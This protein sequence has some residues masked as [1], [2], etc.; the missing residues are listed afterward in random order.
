MLLLGGLATLGLAVAL[1]LPWLDAGLTPDEIGNLQPGGWRAVLTDAE[2]AVNPPLWRL[3]A[4]LGGGG[5]VGAIRLGRFLSIAA[6]AALVPV[7]LLVGTRAG[8]KGAGLLSALGLAMLPVLVDVGTLHRAYA[9]WGLVALLLQ[10][11][12]VDALGCGG[13]VRWVAVALLGALLVQLH[14]LGV[15][16]LAA[17]LVLVAVE[18]RR[19]GLALLLGVPALLVLAP[20]LDLIVAGSDRRLASPDG[21]L[22]TVLRLASLGLQAPPEVVRIAGGG[23]RT[24]GIDAPRAQAWTGWLVVV[25]LVLHLP[26]LRR[27]STGRRVAWVGAVGVLG[28]AALAARGQYVRPHAASQLA[29][30]LVPLLAA[31]PGASRRAWVRVPGW[32]LLVGLV[33][34]SWVGQLRTTLGLLADRDA[35]PHFLAHAPSWARGR[36]LRVHPS[37]AAGWLW[38]QATGQ[39]PQRY[40]HLGRCERRRDCYAVGGLVWEGV[41][42][43]PEGPALLAS[44]DRNRPSDLAEGCTPRLVTPT[45][46]V[47]DCP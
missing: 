15:V 31:L 37:Y 7:A 38:T 47:W 3:V 34:V 28:S 21:P 27:V 14:Y 42:R 43:R 46:A 2:N 6:S 16:V 10:A 4:T 40:D 30:F 9:A 45:Y 26:F 1:R 11:A 32:A 13:R 33:G 12:I 24:L 44:F 39:A 29:V 5:G 20:W 8:G 22:A 41:D 19:P 35:M 18:G 17:L 23:L 25:V 36:P